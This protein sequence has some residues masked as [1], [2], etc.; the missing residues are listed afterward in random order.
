MILS[1]PATY[2]YVRHQHLK[3][4]E[5]YLLV[6]CWSLHPQ[7]EAVYQ[8]QYKYQSEVSESNHEY[9]S[10]LQDAPLGKVPLEM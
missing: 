5:M 4:T 2:T 1:D 10:L 7:P 6:L 9:H 3:Q 8:L